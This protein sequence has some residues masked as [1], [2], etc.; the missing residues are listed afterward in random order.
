MNGGDRAAN[1]VRVERR[2]AAAWA[3]LDRPERANALGP[4]MVDALRA[5]VR[6]HG[7]EPDVAALVITGTGRTFCPGADVKASA[8][9]G[10][11]QSRLAYLD[12]GRRLMHEIEDAGKPVIAAVNGAAFAGG[13]ELL[14]ACHLVVAAEDAVA[15][16]LHLPHG[17]LPG[18]GGA[19]RLTRAVGEAAATRILLLGERLGAAELLRLGLCSEV[20][21]GAALEETV[22]RHVATLAAHSPAVLAQLVGLLRSIRGRDRAASLDEEWRHFRRHFTAGGAATV[23]LRSQ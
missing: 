9:L 5:F 11:A 20:V 15:G 10:D 12:A 17:R 3:R 8:A 18:W 19:T 7:A 1:G 21:P 14:L 23:S 2:G 4:D 6:E 13:L 16:D 22:D